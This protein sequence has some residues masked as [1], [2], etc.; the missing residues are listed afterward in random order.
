MGA[1]KTTETF[2][3]VLHGPHDDPQPQ[4]LTA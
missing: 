1:L 2:Q 3:S 4:L